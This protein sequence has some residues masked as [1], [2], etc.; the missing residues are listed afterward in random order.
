MTGHLGPL[1]LLSCSLQLFG[2]YFIKVY[3]K[4][5]ARDF[6]EEEDNLQARSGRQERVKVSGS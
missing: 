3:G 6:T 5:L 1:W 4:G 2:I